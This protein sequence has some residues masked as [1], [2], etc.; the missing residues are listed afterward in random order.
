[1][2]LPKEPLDLGFSERLYLCLFSLAISMHASPARSNVAPDT[3]LTTVLGY[4]AAN[5]GSKVSDT[6]A[7]LLFSQSSLATAYLQARAS[8]SS[9]CTAR[10]HST[11]TRYFPT[12]TV[13]D[14]TVVIVL[15]MH[16]QTFM[17]ESAFHRAPLAPTQT[18]SPR[19]KLNSRLKDK[20]AR[21]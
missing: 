7:S 2:N 9:P 4:Y 20:A 11:H 16:A 19:I 18:L 10:S 14:R 6:V 1:M 3:C 13:L 12:A 5:M 15:Y 21:H 17:L 8:T